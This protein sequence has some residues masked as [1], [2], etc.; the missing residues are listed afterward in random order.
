MRAWVLW[1]N[2][3]KV[4]LVTASYILT[5]AEPENRRKHQHSYDYKPEVDKCPQYK[6]AFGKIESE[7]ALLLHRFE[8]Q[9]YLYVGTTCTSEF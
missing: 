3:I 7:N 4:R 2:I 8:Q 5:T 1:F 9:N 6:K